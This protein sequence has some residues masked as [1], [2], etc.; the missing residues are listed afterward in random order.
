M[1][2]IIIILFRLCSKSLVYHKAIIRDNCMYSY[3]SLWIY[4]VT[5]NHIL[6]IWIQLKQPHKNEKAT[7]NNACGWLYMIRC[8]LCLFCCLIY[9]SNRQVQSY[10]LCGVLFL[11]INN[12]CV[13][14]CCAYIG[15]TKHF[16]DGIDV[17][18]ARQLE[19][20]IRV[21]EAMERDMLL[22]ASCFNPSFDRTIYPR[23]S[24]QPCKHK[25]VSVLSFST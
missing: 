3:W 2:T 17:C 8:K 21:S 11:C 15:M 1:T 19:R 4:G 6:V 16:A 10:S 13:D 7:H 22:Y 23:W 18:T 24:W 14:L 25:Q 12:L 5:C 9:I 20:S